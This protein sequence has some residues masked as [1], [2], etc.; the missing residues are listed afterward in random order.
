MLIVQSHVPF[1]SSEV[2]GLNTNE[3]WRH[4]NLQ[5]S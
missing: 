5:R 2:D 3:G 4:T 1:V